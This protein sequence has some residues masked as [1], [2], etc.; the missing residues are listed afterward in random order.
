MIIVKTSAVDPE[1]RKPYCLSLKNFPEYDTFK[2]F[3]EDNKEA[4]A[5]IL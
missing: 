3:T 2:T 4:D 1:E 5:V